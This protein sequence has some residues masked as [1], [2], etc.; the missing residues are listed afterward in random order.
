VIQVDASEQP[1][2]AERWGVFSAPT[3]FVLDPDHMPR[4]VN[5]GVASVETLKKQLAAIT[6]PL[7]SS[8]QSR[9]VAKKE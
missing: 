2:V 3:T 1:D 9:L 8:Y 5:R 7:A 4:Q 6:W